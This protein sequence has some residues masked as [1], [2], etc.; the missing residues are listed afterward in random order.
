MKIIN[1]ILPLIILSVLFITQN[2]TAQRSGVEIWGQTCG[3]CHVMQPG[4]RYTAKQ[5]NSIMLHMQVNARLSDEETKAV[6]EYLKFGASDAT[7]AVP[8]SEDNSG[9]E[10]ASIVLK[11]QPK[12]AQGQ[13]SKEEAAKIKAFVKKSKKDKKVKSE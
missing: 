13:L 10:V 9:K 8:A 6:L 11:E 2:A 4:S 5:W 1:K 3:N 12:K 7:S